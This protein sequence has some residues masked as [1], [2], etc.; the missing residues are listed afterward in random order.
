MIRAVIPLVLALATGC[1]YSVHEVAL[2]SVEE[3]RKDEQPR[4]IEAEAS[5][6]AFIAAGDTD[7]ADE[8][9]AELAGKCPRGRV[10][11]I[12]AR[13]STSLGFLVHENHL[14]VT[15]YCIDEKL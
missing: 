9:M 6:H 11:G 13:H 7:F 2:G 15:G 10:V 5:Q 8:A 3:V 1:A 14:R 4:F 12:Q